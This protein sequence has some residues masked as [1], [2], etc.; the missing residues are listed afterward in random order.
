MYKRQP[1]LTA[2]LETGYQGVA[3]TLLEQRKSQHLPPHGYIAIVRADST[4]PNAAT[5]YLSQ[6]REQLNQLASTN[7]VR[8]VGPM[9]ALMERRAGRHRA[10]LMLHSDKRAELHQ[11]ASA[12][13]RSADGI[14][15]KSS[16]RWSID[17]DPMEII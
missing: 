11:V 6:L 17:I 1:L 2:W 12:A 5:I 15:A 10:Q 14:K 16:L 13:I 4:E 7:G 8:L 3:A 9:P